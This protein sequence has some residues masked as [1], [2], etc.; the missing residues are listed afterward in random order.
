MAPSKKGG[1]KKKG[2]FAINEVVTREYTISV[3]KC[4][5]GVGFKKCAP[6]ALKEIRGLTIWLRR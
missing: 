5:Y 1:E 3:H 2:R 6:R 4:I